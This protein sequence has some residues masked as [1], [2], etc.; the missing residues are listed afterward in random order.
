MHRRLRRLAANR[1]DGPETHFRG[2]AQETDQTHDSVSVERI[3]EALE[4]GQTSML[5]GVTT[6]E[7][8]EVVAGDARRCRCLPVAE[9]PWTLRSAFS[10]GF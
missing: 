10:L 3:L 1:L 5:F 9:D 4:D 6:P 2:M 8:E 7:D